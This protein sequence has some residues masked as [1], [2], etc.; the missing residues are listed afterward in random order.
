MV[1]K[2]KF[3]TQENCDRC[4]GGLKG[5]RTM[6][7]FSEA[8]ICMVCSDMEQQDPDYKKAVEADHEQIKRGNYNYAGIRGGK[9]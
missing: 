6:S 1:V 8:C 9:V 5:C 3:F 2:D 7:K 4:G